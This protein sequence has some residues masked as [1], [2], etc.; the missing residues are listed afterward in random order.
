M[1]NFHRSLGHT[2]SYGL[3][4]VLESHAKSRC[5]NSWLFNFSIHQD[6]KIARPIQQVWCNGRWWSQSFN[7]FHILWRGGKS[8]GQKS[9]STVHY[10]EMMRVSRLISVPP[11]KIKCHRMIN[12]LIKTSHGCHLSQDCLHDPMNSLW[13]RILNINR[14]LS[15]RWVVNKITQVQFNTDYTLISK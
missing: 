2:L 15:V 6:I 8:R 5:V 1:D 14:Q 11:C 3:T 13:G 4:L 7:C 12:T 9:M 10:F